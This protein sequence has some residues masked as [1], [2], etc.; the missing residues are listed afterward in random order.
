MPSNSEPGDAVS[1]GDIL[2]LFSVNTFIA[3][4]VNDPSSRRVLKSPL[5]NLTS[6]ISSY[7]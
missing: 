4:K 7:G 5:G 1:I 2:S 6:R 3:K